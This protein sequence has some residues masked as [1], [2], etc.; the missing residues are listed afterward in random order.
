MAFELGWYEWRSMCYRVRSGL[1]EDK[2]RNVEARSKSV[3]I[4]QERGSIGP[5]II[6]KWVQDSLET[7]VGGH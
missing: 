3:V 5:L 1:E 6:V 7:T 2:E 4:S